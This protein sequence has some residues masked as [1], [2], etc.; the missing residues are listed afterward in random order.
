[1]LCARR[2]AAIHYAHAPRWRDQLAILQRIW[3]AVTPRRHAVLVVSAGFVGKSADV[4]Q[5][6]QHAAEFAP[7][8]LAAA[9]RS[10]PCCTAAR[11]CKLHFEGNTA[12]M[13]FVAIAIELLRMVQ[14]EPHLDINFC[15]AEY[16]PDG[17]FRSGSNWRY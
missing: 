4:P 7:D 8:C 15:C 9:D 16:L 5:V 1:M 14:H 11:A 10:H 6:Q 17:G 12:S 13:E 2:P 3:P